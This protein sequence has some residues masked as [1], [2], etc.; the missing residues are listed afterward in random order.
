[1][2][3]VAETALYFSDCTSVPTSLWVEARVCYAKQLVF[4]RSIKTAIEVLREIC[5][6]IPPLPIDDLTFREESNFS[7]KSKVPLTPKKNRMSTDMGNKNL[8]QE[9]EDKFNQ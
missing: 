4:E 3:D 7:K 9:M 6:L 5:F 8:L 1:M 2:R